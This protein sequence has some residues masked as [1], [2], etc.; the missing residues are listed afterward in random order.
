MFFC[1]SKNASGVA[2]R[3]GC[4]ALGETDSNRGLSLILYLLIFFE[5]EILFNLFL[6]F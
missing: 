1:D 5:I 4:T 2:G 6:N 3:P